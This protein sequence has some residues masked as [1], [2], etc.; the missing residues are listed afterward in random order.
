MN[1]SYILILIISLIT[2]LYFWNP[3]SKKNE[4]FVLEL[5][6]SRFKK[7]IDPNI[8][9]YELLDVKSGKVVKMINFEKESVLISFWFTGCHGCIYEF[10]GLEKLHTKFPNLKMFII[11]HESPNKIRSFMLKN[12]TNL[13][14]YTI[15]KSN[16]YTKNIKIWPTTMFYAKRKM[17]F[18]IQNTGNYDDNDIFDILENNIN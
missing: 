14:F 1:K 2:L 17:I 15:Y 18:Q 10:P 9:N 4:K 6:N 13:P 3:T 5:K 16:T 8:F 12:Y 7:E 11:S